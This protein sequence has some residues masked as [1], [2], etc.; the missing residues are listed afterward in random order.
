[1][2]KLFWFLSMLFIFTN[3]EEVIDVDI[4]AEKPRLIVEA[5]LRIDESKQIQTAQ[6]KVGLTDSFYG[7]VSVTGLKQITIT[8]VDMPNTFSNPNTIFLLEVEP[9]VYEKQKN[10]AFFT[11]GELVF[12]FE[13]GE[14]LY[15]ARTHYVPAP[16]IDTLIQDISGIATENNSKVDITFTDEPDRDDFYLFDL[17][18]EEFLVTKDEFYQG[19]QFQF[20]HI[21]EKKIE[22]GEEVEVNILGVDRSFYNYMDLI[23]EQSEASLNLFATPVATIRGNIINVTNI[24]NIDFFDNV[25]Q[26]NNFAL[27]YFA[28]VQSNSKSVIIK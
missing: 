7:E 12:Q 8:N 2:K 25:N 5:L 15:L 20:S 6:V 16:A 21:Y 1:M 26:T 4:P 9:G 24:D 10:T 3:C 22:I 18:F 27:G 14:E 19:Q 13:H 17:G 23:I 11:S 28:V